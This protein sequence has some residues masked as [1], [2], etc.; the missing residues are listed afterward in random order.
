[1]FLALMW[2]SDPT[3]NIEPISRDFVLPAKFGP[4]FY[5]GKLLGSHCNL[6]G[7]T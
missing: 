7:S 3:A 5:V 1:M 2:L 4:I 6:R